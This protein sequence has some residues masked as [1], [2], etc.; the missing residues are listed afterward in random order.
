MGQFCTLEEITDVIRDAQKIILVTHNDPDGDALGSELTLLRGLSSLGKE[1]KIMNVGICSK[2]YLWMLKEAEAEF[3]DK[4]GPFPEKLEADLIIGLDFNGWERLLGFEKAVTTSGITTAVVDHHPNCPPSADFSL[5]DVEASCTG[6]LVWDILKS[7]GVTLSLDMAIP[8][9]VTLVTDTGHFRYSNTN[10]Q[11]HRLAVELLDL[12]VDP[13]KVYKHIYESSSLNRLK[14]LGLVLNNVK[15]TAGGWAIYGV[16]TEEDYKEH[17]VT[18]DETEGFIDHIRT[19]EGSEV[20]LFFRP[21]DLGQI[22]VSM[23]SRVYDISKFAAIFN[24][25]GHHHAAGMTFDCSMSEAVEKVVAELEKC[26]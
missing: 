19:L 13:F 10:A 20:S 22:K 12:G 21:D 25:G 7:L 18:P 16:L 14:L 1:V 11:S 17:G 5:V 3:I 26:S 15:T 6:M 4:R 2:L 8:C 9:Y 24:G 23:R